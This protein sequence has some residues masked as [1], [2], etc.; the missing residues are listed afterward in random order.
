MAL[1]GGL[2][3]F[4]CLVPEVFLAHRFDVSTVAFDRSAMPVITLVD[5]DGLR[6]PPKI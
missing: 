4:V 5:G 3:S 1:H 6:R 2:G